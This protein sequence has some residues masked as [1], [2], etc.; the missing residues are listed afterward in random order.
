MSTDSDNTV[1]SRAEYS[2]QA[3]SVVL[4][5]Y[6]YVLTLPDEIQY[7]WANITTRKT[8][9]FLYLCCRYALAANLIHL[10]G[11]TE[12]ITMSCTTINRSAGILAIFGHIGV[13][14]VWA[15]RTCAIC[16]G[17]R[18]VP[19]ILGVL[20]ASILGLRIGG[21]VVSHCPTTSSRSGQVGIA[22]AALMFVFEMSAFTLAAMRVWR[23]VRHEGGFGRNPRQSIN[24]IILSQGFLY[25]A[26][27]LG[28]T[29]ISA[30]LNLKTWGGIS[31]PLNSLKLPLS[32]LLTARFLLAL[33]SWE[34]KSRAH[35][36]MTGSTG[37]SF[38]NQAI[39]RTGARTTRFDTTHTGEFSIGTLST[40]EHRHRTTVNFADPPSQGRTTGFNRIPLVRQFYGDVGPVETRPR[41][42]VISADVE[43]PDVD[44]GGVV[45]E[46]MGIEMDNVPV[47]IKDSS[48]P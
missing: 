39:N 48:G 27:V 42:T 33:R 44:V 37:I 6:D 28:L 13:M 10:L 41:S 17:T 29:V 35:S 9:T 38:Q 47:V 2:I 16:N 5:Y 32:A 43:V 25:I 12:G 20:G 4:L 21:E 45:L 26:A 31:R 34:S 14:S 36:T 46:N 30:I 24:Y 3:A 19:I 7:I 40:D 23:S 18:A 8:T 1:L 22:V 15:L 11:K